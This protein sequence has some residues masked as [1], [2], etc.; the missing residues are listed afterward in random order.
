[1]V[2]QAAE[3]HQTATRDLG[4]WSGLPVFLDR[5]AAVLIL[6]NLT[7]TIPGSITKQVIGAKATL[8]KKEF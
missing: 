6:P 2:D 4:K 3:D 7:E 8:D 1:M 5:L